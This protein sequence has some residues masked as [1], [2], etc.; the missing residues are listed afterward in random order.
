MRNESM[1]ARIRPLTLTYTL[2]GCS[3]QEPWVK[4]KLKGEEAV[5]NEFGL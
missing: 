1:E 2:Q 4:L 5:I 3:F